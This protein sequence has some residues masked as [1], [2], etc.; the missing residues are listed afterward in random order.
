M[1]IVVVGASAAGLTTVEAL[2]SGGF[3]GE[4]T[5]IGAEPHLPYDRPPLSKAVLSGDLD[6]AGVTLLAADRW[7]QLEVDLRLGVA[8]TGLDLDAKIIGLAD[9]ATV[10]YDRLVI[11]T[12]VRPR[13]LDP[14]ADDHDAVQVLRTVDD[15][16]TL[17]QRALASTRVLIIGAGFLG[18]E[19][20]ASLTKQDVPVVLVDPAPGPLAALG[21][22][23][24][25]MIADLHREHGVDL[26]C[27]VAVTGFEPHPH[28]RAARLSDGSTVITDC[29]VAAIGAEP[30]TDWLAGSGLELSA[31]VV[32]DDRLL[33]APD[34]YAAGDVAAWPDPDGG[35]P[36]R[37]EHR[38]NATEQA[39]RVAR[40]LLGADEP[41]A[42]T[43]Y[44][45][46]DQYD[47]KLQ[48]YGT[49]RPED[50]RQLVQGS[51]AD[52]R[53]VALVRRGDRVAGAIGCGLPRDLLRYRRL[54]AARA[55]WA[56]AVAAEAS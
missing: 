43:S 28:G 33:A 11:A 17:R 39:I 52:R 18:T 13:R 53:F 36:I 31:G 5:L 45:W 40:N 32:C 9:G 46:T 55:P 15:A 19:I 41:Y 42:P 48:S 10:A 20:A 25:A 56:E 7:P 21:P 4:L 49:F 38:M 22:D 54:V 50:P 8:A 37:V 44:F 47:L 14:G 34:V 23:L 51:L 2:R 35:R 6:A 26:R 29:V 3:D 30:V 12:G 24:S 27:G 16:L 1:R